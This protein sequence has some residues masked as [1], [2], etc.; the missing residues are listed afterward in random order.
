MKK[1]FTLLLAA[2]TVLGLA[3]C[4]KTDNS[5]PNQDDSVKIAD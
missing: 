5:N 4:S 1:L 2:V 3:A